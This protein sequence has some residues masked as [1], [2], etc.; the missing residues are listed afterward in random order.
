MI[1]PMKDYRKPH[2]VGF[3]AKAFLNGKE[4][5]FCYDLKL[6]IEKFEKKLKFKDFPKR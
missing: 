2:P 1:M 6:N 5:G 4:I 3:E